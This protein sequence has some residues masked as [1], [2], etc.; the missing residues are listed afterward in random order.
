MNK[1]LYNKLYEIKPH[2]D[3]SFPYNT[4]ICSIPLDFSIVPTHWHNEIELIIIK[5]GTGTIQ[6]D[7]TS[8]IV[9]PNDIILV[10]PGQLHSIIQKN[11]L[12]M[13]YENIIFHPNLLINGNSDSRF[14]QYFSPFLNMEYDLACHYTE[15][16]PLHQNLWSCIQN[17]DSCSSLKPAFYELSIQ[18]NLFQFFFHLFSHQDYLAPLGENLALT[19]IKAILTYIELHYM[20]PITTEDAAKYMA[21]SASHFMKLFKQNMNTTFIT[22][23]NTYRLSVASRLLITTNLSILEV[24]EQSG[25]GNLSYFNRQF[26]AYYYMTP[27]TYRKRRS[28]QANQNSLS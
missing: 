25:F 24:A 18:S 8:Y 28:Y 11:S 22:Y 20:E 7:S 10:R 14:T 15:S 2:G 5:K 17:I 4:Y 3:S 27:S 21:L 23:L 12:T 1:S 9:Y 26:K 6:V 16:H 19:K 13:E